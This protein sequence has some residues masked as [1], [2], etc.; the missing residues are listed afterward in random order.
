MVVEVIIGLQ[1][2][3]TQHLWL[4]LR[5]VDDDIG[6]VKGAP[7]ADESGGASVQAGQCWSLTARLKQ[8]H[9]M[10]NPHGFDLELWWFEQ[11]VRAVGTVRAR[12]PRTLMAEHV[13]SPVP[14]WRQALRDELFALVPDARAAGVLAALSLG[15]QGAINRDDWAVFRR[16][17]VAHLVSISGLHITM[18]AWLAQG[19]VPATRTS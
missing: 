14:R 17:G 13:G 15:D 3:D 12:Q 8:A 7:I 16:T 18:F 6:I 9:G 19:L 2:Q 10:V 1:T 5:R 11:G 4:A